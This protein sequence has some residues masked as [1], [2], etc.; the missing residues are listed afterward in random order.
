MNLRLV[1]KM[2]VLK[3]PDGTRVPVLGHGIWNL[4]AAANRCGFQI[5]GLQSGID[6][7]FALIDTAEMYDY[8]AFEKL[9]GGAIQLAGT[10]IHCYQCLPLSGGRSCLLQGCPRFGVN[11]ALASN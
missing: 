4:D 1:R 11:G 5:W 6:L 9:V 10:S 2:K 7:W 8:G 3:L